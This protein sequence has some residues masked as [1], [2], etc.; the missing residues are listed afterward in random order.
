MEEYIPWSRFVMLSLG[1]KKTLG[2]INGTFACLDHVDPKY[3]GW[4]ANI[5][6]IFTFSDFA[7]ELWNIVEELYG[8]VNNA[9]RRTLQKSCGILLKNFVDT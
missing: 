8:N 9:A 2:F 1:G 6:E 7:K 3:E 4:I 5:A